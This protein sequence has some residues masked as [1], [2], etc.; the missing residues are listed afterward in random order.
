MVGF[1]KKIAEKG[2]EKIAGKIVK[3]AKLKK[4]VDIKQFKTPKKGILKKFEAAVSREAARTLSQAASGV[5]IKFKKS[6]MPH[7]PEGTKSSM[8][9]RAKGLSKL[10]APV[11]GA[12]VAGSLHKD[13]KKEKK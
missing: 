3:H 1:W 2:A 11:V 4:G 10:A 12:K 7:V 13:K 6:G 9:T 8:L 5:N